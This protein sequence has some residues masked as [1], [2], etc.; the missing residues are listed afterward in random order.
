M[1]FSRW[2]LGGVQEELFSSLSGPPLPQA[3][4]HAKTPTLF[5]KCMVAAARGSIISKLFVKADI[6]LCPYTNDEY[7]PKNILKIKFSTIS[8]K[9]ADFLNIISTLI[10]KDLML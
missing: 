7:L 5:L 8:G 4:S 1:G 2:S 6:I 9:K 10:S 3:V